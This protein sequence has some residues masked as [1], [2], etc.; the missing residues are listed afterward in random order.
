MGLLT[1][2]NPLLD[3]ATA[4]SILVVLDGPL[5][6][7]VRLPQPGGA[8]SSKEVRKTAGEKEGKEG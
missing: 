7:N 8:S 6:A 2:S 1:N 3:P 4:V 5:T